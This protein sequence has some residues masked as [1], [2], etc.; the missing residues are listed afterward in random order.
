M[1]YVWECRK[2]EIHIVLVHIHVLEFAFQAPLLNYWELLA[3]FLFAWIACKV[4][5]GQV[6]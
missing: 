2:R 6:I 4:P 1:M 5:E 3:V